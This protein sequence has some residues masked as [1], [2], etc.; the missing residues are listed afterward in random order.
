MP[1]NFRSI[2]GHG[3]TAN[4]G[5]DERRRSGH[6]PGTGQ[7]AG[8]AAG[9][10]PVAVADRRPMTNQFPPQPGNPWEPQNP[11]DPAAQPPAYGYL[12]PN[13]T[14]PVGWPMIHDPLVTGPN[15]GVSGFFNRLFAIVRRS[16]KP[17]LLIPW[18]TF[19]GPLV[20]LVVAAGLTANHIVVLPPVGS[21]ARPTFDGSL[22]VTLIV[23]LIPCA[24]VIGFLTSAAQAA[25]VWAVT[26]QAAG[27]PAPLGAALKF[28]LRNG[29]RLWGWSLLYGLMIG[30]GTCACVIPGLYLALAGC[31]Y[32]PLALY[33]RDLSPLTTS[34]S[35]VHRNFGTALGRMLL[36]VLLVYGVS[37]VIS[38]PVQIVSLTSRTLSVVLAGLLELVTAPLTLLIAVATVLLFAELWAKQQPTTTADLDAALD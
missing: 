21:T 2:A 17:L 33:R 14:A 19:A 38:A 8:S 6:L 18:A 32:I 20:V 24:I 30:V 28:G 4:G 26:R 10:V 36:V 13:P 35:L 16:W 25:A 5:S 12:V 7:R 31:L 9:T 34:F 27:R 3:A 11:W 37:A 23:I 1:A 22:L 29:V 15:E